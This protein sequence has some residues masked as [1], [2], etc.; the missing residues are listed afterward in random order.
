[1]YDAFLKSGI[2]ANLHYIPVHRQPY[3]ERLGFQAGYCPEAE[4][5]HRETISLPI[6]PSMTGSDQERVIDL[7]ERLMHV[8]V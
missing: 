8:A 5:F 3:Y 4:L 6:F 7:I 2:G 1:V